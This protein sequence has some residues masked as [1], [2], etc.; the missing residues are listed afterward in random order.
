MQD[1]AY[2]VADEPNGCQR[3][4]SGHTQDL[5]T[6]SS[7]VSCKQWQRQTKVSAYAATHCKQPEG[8]DQ[9]IPTFVASDDSAQSQHCK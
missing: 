5:A 9:C 4:S 7:D 2:G 3:H 6:D 1:H 8:D